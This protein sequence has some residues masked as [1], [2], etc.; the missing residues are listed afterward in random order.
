MATLDIFG[1][2]RRNGGNIREE[3]SQSII[4]VNAYIHLDEIKRRRHNPNPM[5]DAPLDNVSMSIFPNDIVWSLRGENKGIPVMSGGDGE[6]RVM[7]SLNRAFDKST[8]TD[9]ILGMINVVG[10][11]GGDGVVFER[12]DERMDRVAHDFSVIIDGKVTIGNNSE[13]TILPMQYVMV[14]LPKDG[15]PSSMY[16]RVRKGN[17]IISL[18]TRAYNPDV[19]GRITVKK[20]DDV[21]QKVTQAGGN[22]RGLSLREKMVF[23]YYTAARALQGANAPPDAAALKAAEE[24]SEISRRY[25]SFVKRLVIGY[26][27]TGAAPGGNMHIVLQK[28]L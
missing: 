9:A 22:T 10:V 1:R 27:P 6:I 3:T 24:M 15:D 21:Q 5:F 8:D 26:T 19:D 16:N 14:D 13:E 2:G 18:R 20:M 25:E 23:E 4:K 17:T 28:I 7:S 11:A 12:G